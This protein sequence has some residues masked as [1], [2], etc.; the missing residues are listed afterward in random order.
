MSGNDTAVARPTLVLRYF[1]FDLRFVP[2]YVLH[3]DAGY[4]IPSH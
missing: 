2:F 3:G 1:M 4:A